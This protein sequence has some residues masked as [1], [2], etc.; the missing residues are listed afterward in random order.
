MLTHVTFAGGW[1][2]WTCKACPPYRQDLGKQQSL[3]RMPEPAERARLMVV[4]KST[5]GNADITLQPLPVPES[6]L[7]SRN[8]KKQAG[9]WRISDCSPTQP[10]VCQAV[11]LCGN[12]KEP[13]R[14]TSEYQLL[15]APSP[16]AAA[17]PLP[18][19]WLKLWLL[20]ARGLAALW[21]FLRANRRALRVCLW[22]VSSTGNL[23]AICWRQ[24]WTVATSCSTLGCHLLFPLPMYLPHTAGEGSSSQMSPTT[25]GCLRRL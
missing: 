11:L 2:Q 7:Q 8:Q 25:Y 15:P 9:T 23:P 19:A 13:Q 6:A 16:S 21:C 14:G 4:S 5:G 22:T 18:T 3:E 20:W 10:P 24:M 1:E 17:C 12:G